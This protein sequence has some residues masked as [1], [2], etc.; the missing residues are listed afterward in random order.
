MKGIIKNMNDI[1][2]GEG[3]WLLGTC[4]FSTNGQKNYLLLVALAAIVQ[5]VI[6]IIFMIIVIPLALM[7]IA[8]DHFI[9]LF[10]MFN[11]FFILM[12]IP[13]AITDTVI[14]AIL[15]IVFL[16]G[17]IMYWYFYYRE[18][19]IFMLIPIAA[20]AASIAAWFIPLAGPI[21]SVIVSI[22]PWLPMMAMIHWYAYKS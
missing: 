11:P 22:I 15:I 20:W 21:I 2:C 16:A 1:A 4:K 19:G 10:C 7:T 17:N 3:G 14:S 8:I 9:D 5:Y 18:I 6:P 12:Y 13:L